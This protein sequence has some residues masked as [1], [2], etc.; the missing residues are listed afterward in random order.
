M[1]SKA[2]FFPYIGNRKEKE[3]FLSSSSSLAISRS[4]RGRISL[5][6]F[7][8]SGNV[9]ICSGPSRKEFLLFRLA[10]TLCSFYEHPRMLP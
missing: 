2:F 4:N 1:I 7:Q 3:Y 9:G 8:S 10:F 5:I 6:T